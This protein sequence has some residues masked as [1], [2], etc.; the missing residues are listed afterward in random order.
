MKIRPTVLAAAAI[1]L[2]SQGALAQTTRTNPSAS[3]TI[4]SIPSSSSTSPNSPCN[5]NNPTSPCYSANA[6]RAP[7][8]SATSPN[9]PCSTTTT[10][11]SPTLSPSPT[12]TPSGSSSSASSA[13]TTDQAKSRIEEAGYSSVSIL[14]K[15]LKGVW[16][17]NAVKDGRKVTVTLDADGTVH[18]K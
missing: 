6:P 16:R 2:V 14:R 1:C 13:F 8:Y 3:S 10:P 5:P 12:P 9:E 18:A 4:K 11:S 17:A 15:D 7:C